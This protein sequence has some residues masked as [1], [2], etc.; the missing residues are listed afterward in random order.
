[1]PIH[2]RCRPSDIAPNVIA[3][4]DPG[5]V[6][7]IADLL[8]NVRVVN[9]NRGLLVVT[10]FYGGTPVTVATHGMGAGSAS[11]V[12]EELRMLG[13]ERIVRLGTCCALKPGVELGSVIVAFSALSMVGGCSLN[14]YYPSLNPPLSPDP[15]LTVELTNR[16]AKN[17]LNPLRGVVF[18]SDAFYSESHIV[19]TLVKLNVDCVEMET[20]VLFALGWLRGFSTAS[21]LIVSNSVVKEMGFIDPDQLKEKV[22]KTAKTILDVFKDTQT[23]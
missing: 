3:A 17:G 22:L 2:L 1:M 11:I 14:Q 18:C 7:T 16:L 20:A 15:Y 19:D 21:V 8:E 10:G 6:R 12:F 23:G 9:E 5:R 13:A 4:G